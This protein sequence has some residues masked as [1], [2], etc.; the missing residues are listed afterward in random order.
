MNISRNGFAQLFFFIIGA[1]L[2][3]SALATCD[4]TL[5]PGANVASAISSAANDSTICL[6]AGDYGSLNLVNIVKSSDV[7]LKSSSGNT[8]TVSI[9]IAGS[10]HLKFQNLT[11]SGMSISGS[12][13]KNI[14]A[15]GN[16][17]T[18][19]FYVD[20]TNFNNNNILIDGNTFD[21][22]SVCTNCAEGRL[23]ISWGGGPGTVPAGVTVTNNH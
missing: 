7:I 9:S 13:T 4:Q 8:A 1:A 3:Q 11:I 15:A 6:N 12:A 2:S 19:Q 17:F 14:T 16:I 20:T 23:Q 21:G 22:I 18:N 10:S 5:N